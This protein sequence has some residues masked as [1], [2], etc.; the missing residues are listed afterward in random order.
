M[1]KMPISANAAIFISHASAD[2]EIVTRLH[3]ALETMTGLNLWV[4]HRDIALGA[5]WQS[6]IDTALRVC[7]DVLLVLSRHS[8]QSREVIAEWRAALTLN[9]RLLIVIIDDVP[10]Q[11][12]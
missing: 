8:V 12:I 9:R 5:D 3:D 11:D 1:Y 4:D 2:D 10:P 6:E 7:P